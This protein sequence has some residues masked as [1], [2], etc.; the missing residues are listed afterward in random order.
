MFGK[1]PS[2]PAMDTL[3]SAKLLHLVE[4]GDLAALRRYFDKNITGS[5]PVTPGWL[6]LQA[7]LLRNDIPMMRFL[8]TWGARP[9]AES[10]AQL[11][12]TQ[13]KRLRIAGLTFNPIPRDFNTAAPS[14]TPSENPPH[15]TAPQNAQPMSTEI[16]MPGE[17]A[18]VL[19]LFRKSPK[20][21][22]R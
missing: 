17:W 15:K 21:Q 22:R 14:V 2:S 8:V 4:T 19:R 12:D 1:K 13:R 10:V 7:A 16:F 11:T 18:E 5:T 3:D 6:H 20:H 9:D